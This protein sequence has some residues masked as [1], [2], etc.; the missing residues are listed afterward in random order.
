MPRVREDELFESGRLSAAP[1]LID[2]AN[3]HLERGDLRS[4]YTCLERVT[5]LAP[6]SVQARIMAGLLAIRLDDLVAARGQLEA[7][8]RIAPTNSDAHHN[9]ALVYLLQNDYV[10]AL[11]RFRIM[12]KLGQNSAAVL[13]DLAVVYAH[14]GRPGRALVCYR[15][16][17]LLDPNDSRT[18][19][20]AMQYCLE[21]GYLAQ[22]VRM[23]DRQANSRRLTSVA[24]AEGRRWHQIFAGARQVTIRN[25]V[26]S[27]APKLS[28]AKI[29]FFASHQTFLTEIMS[30]VARSNQ[31]KVYDGAE[32][33]DMTGLMRW[34]DVAWFEWCDQLLIDAT[35]LKKTCPIV[36][37]IHSYEVFSDM[38]RQV[39][40]SKV[41]QII[42]VNESV[43]ELFEQ[44][45]KTPVR[46]VVIHNGLDLARFPL[47][48]D[49]PRTKRIGS[50]GYI[51]Y[52][53]NPG[54]LLYCFKKIHEYDSDYTLHIAGEHQDPR[55][56]LYMQN[57]LR[58]HPLPVV[59]NGWVKDMPEWYA[60]KDFVISTSLFE[61]FHYSI[62]EG[63]A[64]GVL[65]LIHDW[66]GADKLYPGQFMFSDP[67]D[68]LRL[69]RS[70][71]TA[72]LPR[73]RADNRQFIAS[74]YNQA[75]RIADI[76]ATLHR[77]L[78]QN[79]G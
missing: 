40:W 12:L 46:K 31:T 33:S 52:K 35:K 28:G 26:E 13:N 30:S 79:R 24:Q 20:N 5:E 70:L 64:S 6:D 69:V 1:V 14:L 2:Q 56:L 57:F 41:D 8:V 72:D 4:A 75:E 50:V 48:T 60:D 45:T 16:A 11:A 54:L 78:K 18:R 74:R 7:A 34:A 3:R 65:P 43:R 51:N 68:C 22:G 61:S 42:F 39:D 32:G 19:N 49:K 76:E 9:L 10:G 15:R 77:V 58:R 37:R 66:Y 67:D 59:F 25:L 44:Q 63:M 27:T 47:K 71:E 23:L 55:I 53:K 17:L 29:A 38:P 21:Q 62:A 36:C 73:L